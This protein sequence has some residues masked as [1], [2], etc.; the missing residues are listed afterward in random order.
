[1]SEH[2]RCTRDVRA[3]LAQG[4]AVRGTHVVVR[5]LGRDGAGNCRWTVSASRR[6]GSA[7]RR[8]RAKRRLRAV[9]REVELPK[10]TDVVVLA[11]PTAASC[12]YEHLRADVERAMGRLATRRRVGART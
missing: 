7:V 1:M 12:S 11:R 2:L 3:V 10:A 9:V 6:V 4:H 8:N 5:G